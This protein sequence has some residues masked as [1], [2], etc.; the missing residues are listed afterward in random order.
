MSAS[1][2]FKPVKTKRAFEEVCDQIRSEIK[3]G[4]IS[5]GDKLPSE[6]NLAEQLKVSRA[7]VREAFRTLE[8]GGVVSLQKG[9]KGGAVVMQGDVRP[10]TQTV[11]DLL[12]L[13]GLSLLDYTEARMCLQKEIIR[14][15]CERGTE[16]D[17]SALDANIARTREKMT[18]SQIEDRTALTVEF[19]AIL[20]RATKNR[21]MEILM[22]AVTEPLAYY[23]KRIGVDRTWDVAASRSKF[24]EHLRA[25]DV[26]RAIAEMVSHMERL[27]A[28]MLTREDSLD[29]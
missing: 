19:Y 27:H 28:Y 9:V 15:A 3:S 24:V 2:G 5:A 11:S 13:G 10:I 6:R 18:Q 17:F 22:S 12:S 7:T 26:D 8:I 1:L 20:A 21:A 25:R 14:M 4:R 16:G 23:I 29:P